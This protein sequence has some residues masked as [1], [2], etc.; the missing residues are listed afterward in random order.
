MSS[1]WT[2]YQRRLMVVT[3][4]AFVMVLA[5]VVALN[6]VGEVSSAVWLIAVPVGLLVVPIVGVVCALLL[7]ADRRHGAPSSG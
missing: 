5:D 4:L 3:A 6:V 1:E 2:R 7:L